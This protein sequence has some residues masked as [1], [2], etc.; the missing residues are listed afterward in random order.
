VLL[1]DPEGR[2]PER[3]FNYALADDLFEPLFNQ[4][5]EAFYFV[6]FLFGLGV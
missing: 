5:K 2:I 6:E 4:S 3:V 1:K